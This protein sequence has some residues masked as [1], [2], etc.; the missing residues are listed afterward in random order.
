MAV[1]VKLSELVDEMQMQN[2]ELSIYMHK[3]TGKYEAIMDHHLQAA[4]IEECLEEF[5][6][7][8]KDT[9]KV[10][11]AILW[12][13][14]YLQLPGQYDTNEWEIMRDFCETIEDRET[15]DELQSAIR[16]EGAFRRFKHQVSKYGIRQEWLDYRDSR[17]AEVARQ[18]CEEHDLEYK[19]DL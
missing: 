7:W 16:G 13:D 10:A 15:R 14:Q 6:E 4:R 12:T 18:W 8:E 17:F 5:T 19:D 11:R 3:E 9:V 2:D 1:T